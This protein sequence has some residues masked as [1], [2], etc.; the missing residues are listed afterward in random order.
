[1][2]SILAVLNIFCIDCFV[3][4]NDNV[5]KIKITTKAINALPIPTQIKERK[6]LLKL[7]LKKPAKVTF[8]KPCNIDNYKDI[9]WFLQNTENLEYIKMNDFDKCCGLNGI[10]KFSEYKIMTNIFEN[11]RENILKT[12]TKY[13]LTSCLG[14]EISLKLFSRNSYQVHDLTN[15]IAGRI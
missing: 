10:S 14:C 12:G 13:V 15:F 2:C 7:S 11:K 4:F 6:L 9:E 3:A 1:M 5:D 8:H